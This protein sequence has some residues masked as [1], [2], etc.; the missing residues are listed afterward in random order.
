MDVVDLTS[1]I[2]QLWLA[3]FL[4]IIM[5]IGLQIQ[6]YRH[7]QRIETLEAQVKAMLSELEE[8]DQSEERLIK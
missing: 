3:V 1:V 8:Q 4:L 5:A 7:G 6:V 2:L